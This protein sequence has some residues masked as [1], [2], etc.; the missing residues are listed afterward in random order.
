M[1]N[2]I[3]IL[4]IVFLASG[5]IFGQTIKNDNVLDKLYFKAGAEFYSLKK[6]SSNIIGD[7]NDISLV[8]SII[9]DYLEN[10]QLEFVYKYGFDR[11]YPIDNIG[12]TESGELIS[13]GISESLT[14]Y[15]IDFKLNYFFNKDKTINP[16]YLT[17]IIEF[18][19]QNKSVINEESRFDTSRHVQKYYKVDIS[20]YNRL[21]T[22]PGIGA[23]IYLAFGKINF[24]SEVSTVYRFAPFVDRGYKEL[25]VNIFTGLAY[26]F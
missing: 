8:G 2:S 9:Y 17:G 24:Q 10:V 23:G 18:D 16:I 7:V 19:I 22:G 13:K 20:S 14:D 11:N 4:I 6:G 21:L 26:K 3:F 15:N 25:L 5:L 1:K 12:Y